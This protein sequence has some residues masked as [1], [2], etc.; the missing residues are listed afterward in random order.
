KLV[1]VAIW[2]QV[3]NCVTFPYWF[4]VSVIAA[5]AA[6]G[7]QNGI[8]LY[9]L[10]MSRFIESHRVVN[11]RNQGK[12]NLAGV[13]VINRA[14]LNVLLWKPGPLN[15]ADSFLI[16]KEYPSICVRW[17]ARLF[18]FFA[19][20]HDFRFWQWTSN[21]YDELLGCLDRFSRGVPYIDHL[22]PEREK[23]RP[24]IEIHRAGYFDFRGHPRPMFNDHLLGEYAYLL[25]RCCRLFLNITRGAIRYG[26]LS[27]A[28]NDQ[29]L[30]L[31]PPRS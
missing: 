18:Q 4:N 8:S 16:R 15:L 1:D 17:L 5:S 6:I 25:V 2:L 7:E 21:A 26:H 20:R 29:P 24:A 31:I 12:V 22:Y 14:S 3:Q 10:M 28:S 13:K 9:G 19:T 30:S 23:R 27:Q 11:T